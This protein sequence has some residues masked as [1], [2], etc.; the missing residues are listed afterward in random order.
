MLGTSAVGYVNWAGM[1]AAYP[2]MAL[3]VMQRVYIP[4]FARLQSRPEELG[5][6]VERVI[7]LTNS[8]T[9]PLA[10]LTL[11]LIE[12]IT[13]LVFGEKWL[14]ALP[15]FYLLWF[16]NLVVATSSPLQGL[17]NA[18]GES[19]TV[20][21]FALLWLAITWVLGIPLIKL[22]G[23]LGLAWANVAVQLT[24]F[25]LF[26]I[27]KTRVRFAIIPLVFPQWFLAGI[28][29]VLVYVLQ[30][31]W[32]INNLPL[33]SVLIVLYLLAYC[34]VLLLLFPGQIAMTIGPL[35]KGEYAEQP[36]ISL[37]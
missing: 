24:N 17:L 12:P 20:F 11:V 6:L 7:W 28:L 32:P 5:R 4:M 2:V 9:A 16:A 18:L 3:M 29:G 27:A 1:V 8:L 30:K 22:M 10:M 26:G 19:R 31:A 21:K 15:I 14:S 13:H 25:S 34:I 37:D 35:K 33:L 36:D 23:E